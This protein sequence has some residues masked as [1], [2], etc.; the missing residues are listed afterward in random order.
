[1]EG[2]KGG[3]IDR[4]RARRDNSAT[5]ARTRNARLEAFLRPAGPNVFRDPFSLFHGL[6]MAMIPVTERQL[7]AVAPTPRAFSTPA[8]SRERP[9]PCGACR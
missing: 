2:W 4:T 6:V 5:V 1:M 7:R 8:A 9:M 3:R